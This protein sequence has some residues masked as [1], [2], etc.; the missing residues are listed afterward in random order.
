M[1]KIFH[2]REIKPR[3][4]DEYGSREYRDQTF[5]NAKRVND[6]S[7]VWVCDDTLCKFFDFF[8]DMVIKDDDP[9]TEYIQNYDVFAFAPAITD[10]RETEQQTGQRVKLIDEQ[11]ELHTYDIDTPIVIPSS[12]TSSSTKRRS[13]LKKDSRQYSQTPLRHS[14]TFVVSREK[15]RQTR[16][17]V[18]RSSTPHRI[19]PRKTNPK[20]QYR[21]AEEP[22]V[23]MD[24]S[25][26]QS[27]SLFTDQPQQRTHRALSIFHKGK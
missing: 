13:S 14:P 3:K 25:N 6:S 4:S 18:K 2:K 16:K 19:L 21:P 23:L 10:G 20:V 9:A 26:E 5:Q 17:V 1:E 27:P 24:E 7:R 11:P 22:Q 12:T 15:G 8:N